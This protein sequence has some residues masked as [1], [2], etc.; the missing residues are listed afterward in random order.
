MAA[1]KSF[2]QYVVKKQHGFGNFVFKQ[3][4]GQLEI[5]FVIQ[6]IQV[7]NHTFVS[8][9]P[10]CEA[11]YLVEDGKSIAHTAV[12]FL[13]DD[14]QGFGFGVDM[15]QFGNV[16]QMVDSVF[17]ADAVEVINLAT[18][19]NSRQY[20]MLFRCGKDEDGMMRR[21]FQCFQKSIE[22]GL[23]QHVDLINDIYLVLADLWRDTYLLN[24]RTDIFYRVVAGGIQL[25]YVVRTL[26]VEC[27]TRLTLIAGF[28]FGSGGL[29]V[30]G[31]GKDTCTRCFSHSTRSAEQV[32]M[33]QLAGGNS[34][35]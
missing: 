14:S 10:T 7:F 19:Q 34:I 23:R 21:F 33:C 9:V 31:F 27:Q 35:F 18:A 22:G 1:V 4:I 15:F 13:C 8:D 25:M 26:F 20:L 12:G 29:A 17:D 30:D 11:D 5:I 16:L 28:A 3:Q 24:Q 2:F 6:D 32:G